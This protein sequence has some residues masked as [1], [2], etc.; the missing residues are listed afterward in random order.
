MSRSL[1]A[2]GTR[3]LSSM[4]A[5]SPEEHQVTWI[6]P[7]GGADAPPPLNGTTAREQA[8]RLHAK[9]II[10]L[11]LACTLLALYDLILLATGS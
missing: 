2:A 5:A 6:Q 7:H 3:C 9:I 10:A 4:S 11:T 1:P 8:D